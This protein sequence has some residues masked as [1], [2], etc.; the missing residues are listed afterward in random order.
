MS[1]AAESAE[2]DLAYLRSLVE[3]PGRVPVA[4]GLIFVTCGAVYAVP[5]FV[6]WAAMSGWIGLTSTVQLLLAGG[7]SLVFAIAVALIVLR[8]HRSGSAG[9]SGRAL[10]GAF[11]A[12]AITDFVLLAMFVPAAI[13]AGSAEPWLL[14]TASA[15]ALQGTGWLLAYLLR[16]LAWIGVVAVGWFVTAIVLGATIGTP[17][18]LL[19]LGVALVLFMILPGLRM[20]HEGHG[21]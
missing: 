13:R 19:T 20:M 11:F 7:P 18:Y 17:L 16:R 3:P 4:A 12:I 1:R 10:M 6:H 2:R 21:A 15:C 9:T 8:E 14:F 5:A